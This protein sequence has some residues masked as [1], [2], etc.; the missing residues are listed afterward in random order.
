MDGSFTR[1]YDKMKD[2]ATYQEAMKII[3]AAYKVYTEIMKA[4]PSPVD[5]IGKFRENHEI[6]DPGEEPDS[7]GGGWFREW[8]IV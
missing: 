5:M 7:G 3:A 4:I 8:W 6:P 1:S 2:P